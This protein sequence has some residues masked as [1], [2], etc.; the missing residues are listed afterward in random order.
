MSIERNAG[1][2]LSRR[3]LHRLQGAY[4]FTYPW[5]I[6]ALCPRLFSLARFGAIS[7]IGFLNLLQRTCRTLWPP[8][9]AGIPQEAVVFGRRHA[10]GRIGWKRP[11]RGQG[12]Q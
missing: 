8:H 10:S 6:A 2:S 12:E 11:Q 4:A 9:P 1:L 3:L 7:A 5:G